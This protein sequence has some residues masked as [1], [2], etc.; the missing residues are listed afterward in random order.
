MLFLWHTPPL[1]VCCVGF[2]NI[3]FSKEKC[4]KERPIDLSFTPGLNEP[5][6]QIC[7]QRRGRLTPSKSPSP[8]RL[9][10]EVASDASLKLRRNSRMLDSSCNMLPTPCKIKPEISPEKQSNQ[11]SPVSIASL[12]ASPSKI[13]PLSQKPHKENYPQMKEMTNKRSSPGKQKL[14]STSLQLSPIQ[15]MPRRRSKVLSPEKEHIAVL[16]TSPYHKFP[17]TYLDISPSRPFTPSF[18]PKVHNPDDIFSLDVPEEMLQRGNQRHT[19]LPPLQLPVMKRVTLPTKSPPTS[20]SASLS[21]NG[22]PTRIQRMKWAVL[23]KLKALP[24]VKIQVEKAPRRGVVD[25]ALLTRWHK[26]PKV[27]NA[28]S[29]CAKMMSFSPL[30]GT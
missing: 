12:D 25:T 13:F 24:S 22:S 16:D 30:S 20:P 19:S 2:E 29:L 11:F 23:S 15:I 8:Q 28:F 9:F 3:N 27:C 21:P 17:S 10:S 26:L 7:I 6:P 14:T 18:L 4:S 5:S 1:I